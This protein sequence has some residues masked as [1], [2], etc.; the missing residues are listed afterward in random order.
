VTALNRLSL[1]K[2]PSKPSNSGVAAKPVAAA[3]KSKHDV[4]EYATD[5]PTGLDDIGRRVC[6]MYGGRFRIGVVVDFT[7]LSDLTSPI[8]PDEHI[9]EQQDH[10]RVR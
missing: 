7:P 6:V 5:L 2:Q 1:P 4:A 10:W 9:P 3:K 8:K